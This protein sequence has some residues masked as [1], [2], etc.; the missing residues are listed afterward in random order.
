DVYALGAILYCMLVGKPPHLSDDLL[1]R[2]EA[3]PDLPGRLLRY[4][5][6]IT[7]HKPPDEHRKVPG[8]DRALAGIVDR[9]LAPRPSKRFAN[10][11]E[12]LD[13][14]QTR[15]Q[16]R[17]R[18]PLLLLGVLGPLL[19]LMV[20][21][22]G[23]RDVYRSAMHESAKAV[24][25]KVYE[26]N[27][28]ASQFVAA[29][30]ATEIHRYFRAVERAAAGTELRENIKATVD[31]LQPLLTEL[32]DPRLPE[33][34]L[35]RK[36]EVF[37]RE[38][39]RQELQQTIIELMQDPTYPE[40]ASWFVCDERGTHLAGQFNQIV[41]SS[42][43][44]NFAY[45]T[46]C[47]G[48]L[49]DLPDKKARPMPAQHVRQTSLSAPLSSGT[50]KRWKIAVSTPLYR[51]DDPQRLLAVLVLTVDVGNFMT[52]PATDSHFAVL[53]DGRDNGYQGIIL[54]HPLL[55]KLYHEGAGLDNEFTLSDYRV[56]L[57]APLTDTYTY[58]D[59][60]GAAPGGEA[61]AREWIAAFA[62]VMIPQ[63]AARGSNAISSGLVVLVQEDMASATTPVRDL[64][65]G[66][67]RKG[68]RALVIFLLVVALLWYF[69]FHVQGGRRWWRQAPF[70][71]GS[72]VVTPT[73]AHVRSVSP[74]RDA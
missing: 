3:A 34:L 8:V 55:T 67:A 27:L 20:M 59:P 58:V 64:G 65:R 26:S 32:A 38:A 13:A 28:F 49:R 35:Q 1:H 70:T 53:V 74:D 23:G 31:Q 17:A 44:S 24:T 29:T 50:T 45:R 71:P 15:D 2:I 68:I 33:E 40:V 51:E 42:I 6:W 41:R 60:M 12:V 14:L 18:R 4:R 21:A 48:G 72:S 62:P 61:Y 7:S 63:D 22:Y 47:Y 16:V 46:Y 30:V 25:S 69:V 9:C 10:V 54:D 5:Q 11:Q 36:R 73:P 43:G 37:T 19:L 52:F 57:D 56:A 39:V 66:L